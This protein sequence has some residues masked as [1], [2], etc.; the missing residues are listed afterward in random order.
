VITVDNDENMDAN[1]VHCPDCGCVFHRI[2]HLRKFTPESMAEL[3]SRI[4]F[5]TLYSGATNFWQ[6]KD[7]IPLKRKIFLK[8]FHKLIYRNKPPHLVYIGENI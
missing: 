8:L 3:M 1:M 7:N 4:G 6:Y 2:Q 5:R